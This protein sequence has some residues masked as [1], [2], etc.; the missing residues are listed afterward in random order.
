MTRGLR[1]VLRSLAFPALLL[2][3]WSGA[4][5]AA[6]PTQGSAPEARD[7]A[8][9]GSN[10]LQSR[11]AYQPII[12]Q[13]GG[14]LIAY[15]GHHGGSV[16]NPLTGQM[17]PNGTSIVDV[18]DPRDPRYLRHVPGSAA[19]AGEAGGAQMLR[20]CA[21]KDLPSGDPTKHTCFEASAISRTSSWMCR[22]PA[23]RRS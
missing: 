3:F 7:M 18:T 11:S 5:M 2:L 8:L 12:Q 21:G 16:L 14:R 19:G 15:I 9:V 17:E 1:P 20:A 6:Q 22:T 4:P 10:D 13:Q 23:T